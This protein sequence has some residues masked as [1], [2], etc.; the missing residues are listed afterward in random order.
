MSEHIA[1]MAKLSEDK[2]TILLGGWVST[3]LIGDIKCIMGIDPDA[4]LAKILG[5]EAVLKI[6]E[7]YQRYR[8]E[9]NK[10]QS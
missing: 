1:V 6:N 2:K 8:D 3:E 5:E 10:D 9:I 7:Q 4:E